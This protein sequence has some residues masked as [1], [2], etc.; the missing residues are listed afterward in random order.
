M[1]QFVSF[2]INQLQNVDAINFKLKDI[3]KNKEQKI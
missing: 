2:L 3:Y 1:N